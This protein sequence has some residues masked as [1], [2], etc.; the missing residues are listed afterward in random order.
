MADARALGKC[1]EQLRQDAKDLIVTSH[2]Q[3]IK[4]PMALEFYRDYVSANKPVIITGCVD[5]WPA[6]TKWT[7]D[8]L[9]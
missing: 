3:R 9:R 4:K 5:D 2:I 8:Y 1:F 6:M 7:N